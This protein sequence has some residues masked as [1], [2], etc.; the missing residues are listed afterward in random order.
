MIR[1]MTVALLALSPFLAAGANAAVIRVEAG[2]ARVLISDDGRWGG[3]MV[4][5]DRSLAAEG[6][7]C[8][9]S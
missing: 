3:C 4:A 6:L 8:P 5:L 1:W 9:G 7:D 2:V